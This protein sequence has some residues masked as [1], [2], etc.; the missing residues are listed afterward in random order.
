MYLSEQNC[1]ADGRELWFWLCI[2]Q[3][4]GVPFFVY[5]DKVLPDLQIFLL[6]HKALSGT[7][8]QDMYGQIPRNALFG[9]LRG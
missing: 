2:L 1:S 7:N 9:T 6:S 4:S 3:G 5:A 8:L